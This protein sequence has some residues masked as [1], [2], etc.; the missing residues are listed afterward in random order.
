[1][2]R[3]QFDTAATECARLLDGD[4][5]AWERW[6]YGFA[7]RRRLAAIVPYIPT[8]EPRLPAAVYEIVLEH[9]LLTDPPLFLETLRRSAMYFTVSHLFSS[10]AQGE[11]HFRAFSS[12]TAIVV[13]SRQWTTRQLLLLLSVS[14]ESHPITAE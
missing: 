8:S 3:G 4:A 5:T 6:I 9:L 2:G 14:Y 10:G 13:L 12:A 11:D 7:R 1:M